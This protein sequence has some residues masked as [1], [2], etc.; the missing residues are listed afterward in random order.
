MLKRNKKLKS[1]IYTW[2]M[3]KFAEEHAIWRGE[4][5]DE[6]TKLGFAPQLKSE[7]LQSNKLFFKPQHAMLFDR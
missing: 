1:T 4:S 3:S 6:S 2:V 5:P 7:R